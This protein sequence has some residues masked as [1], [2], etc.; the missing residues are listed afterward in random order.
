[1]EGKPLGRQATRGDPNIAIRAF[2]DIKFA[3]VVD[4][5]LNEPINFSADLTQKTIRKPR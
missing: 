5:F 1:V 2:G 4:S 3:G